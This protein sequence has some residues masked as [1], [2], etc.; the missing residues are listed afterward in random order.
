MRYLRV[1]GSTGPP[2]DTPADSQHLKVP[3]GV[4]TATGQALDLQSQINKFS[5][6]QLPSVVI[7]HSLSDTTHTI[8]HPYFTR[9]VTFSHITARQ[10]CYSIYAIEESTNM[11]ITF[12]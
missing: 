12:L 11:N 8:N 4:G 9:Q 5:A 7:I 3:V 2:A 1:P 10:S 6:P